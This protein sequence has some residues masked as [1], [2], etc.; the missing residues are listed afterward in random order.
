MKSS[1]LLLLKRV[2]PR[3]WWAVAILAGIGI[4]YAGHLVDVHNHERKAEA[5]GRAAV[6][7]QWK[8]AKLVQ[9]RQRAETEAQYRATE[10]TWR[11]RAQET[12]DAYAEST[13]LLKMAA[14]GRAVAAD[15]V[16]NNLTTIAAAASSA[17]SAPGAACGPENER[18]GRLAGLL[19]E[20]VGLVE[21]GAGRVEWLDAK[22]T[23]LQQFEAAMEAP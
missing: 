17:A 14:A 23:A 10:A 2:S 4:V 5:R 16:R 1:I 20:G 22:V 8:A 21:E 6:Q 15:G 11:Q 9:E 19:A 3:A 18:I 7:A 12:E 13:R